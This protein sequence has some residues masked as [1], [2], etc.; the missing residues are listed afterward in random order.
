MRIDR[1]KLV[2]LREQRGWRQS[3]L[4]AR[5]GLSG[6]FMSQVESGRR[7]PSEVTVAELARVLKVEIADLQEPVMAP[8]L[9]PTCGQPLP[10]LA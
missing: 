2:T 1:T 9:C 3:D 10:G 4:A 5:A 6:G 7:E 8:V